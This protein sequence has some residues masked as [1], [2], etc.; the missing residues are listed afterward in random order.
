MTE[1]QPLLLREML[2]SRRIKLARGH[3]KQLGKI[4]AEL[5]TCRTGVLAPDKDL[6]CSL[7]KVQQEAMACFHNAI[8]NLGNYEL[9]FA[10]V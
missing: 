2:L 5:S 7:R 4:E 9:C 6:C 3:V 10:D 1:L 8:L